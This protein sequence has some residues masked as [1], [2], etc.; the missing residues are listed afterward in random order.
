MILPWTVIFSKRVMIHALKDE[1]ESADTRPAI[2][3]KVFDA[4]RRNR[5]RIRM[6]ASSSRVPAAV[7]PSPKLI[8][9][10]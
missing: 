4:I 6:S 7:H 8:Q 3:P 2:P 5:R 1:S 9:T 10:R